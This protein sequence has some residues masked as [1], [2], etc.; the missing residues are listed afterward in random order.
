MRSARAI[1]TD[2]VEPQR[3]L[4]RSRCRDEDVPDECV[5]L[6]VGLEELA[7]RGAGGTEVVKVLDR[8]TVEV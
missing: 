5:E 7:E 2:L 8:H 1:V 6:G 3:A 4:P